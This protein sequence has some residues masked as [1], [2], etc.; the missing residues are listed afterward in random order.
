MVFFLFIPESLH[1]TFLHCQMYF[2]GKEGS[3][4]IRVQIK[5]LRDLEQVKNLCNRLCNILYKHANILCMY[6]YRILYN[7]YIS[8]T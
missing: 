6:E 1:H 3:V 7:V 8:I 4:S 5:Q 2:S